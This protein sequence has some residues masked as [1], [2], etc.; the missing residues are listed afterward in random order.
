MRLHH[1][2]LL[3]ALLAAS[4]TAGTAQAANA[5]AANAESDNYYTRGYVSKNT[6]TV[7]LQPDPAGPKLYRGNVK[8]EDYQRMLR[9]GYELL[10]YSNFEAADVSPDQALEHARKIHADLVLVYSSLSGSVPLSVK[11]QQLREKALHGKKQADGSTAVEVQKPGQQNRYSYFAS[12]WVK[13]APPIIGVHV[14]GPGVNEET[15]GLE[16]VAVIKDSPAA[17]A[18]IAE[19]D[20]LTRIGEIELN[21][22]EALG[23]AAQRYAG[24]TVEVALKHDG[25]DSTTSMTLNPAK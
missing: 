5:D 3:A 14:K 11:M 15:P 9:N 18:N 8:E 6:P 21:K 13:L 24:K 25:S 23:R 4:L 22:P 20:V 2:P 7:A 1:A 10:G 16:V 12:Y 19:G 17:Q